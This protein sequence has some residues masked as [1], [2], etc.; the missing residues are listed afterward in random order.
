MFII[1]RK[2]KK[3]KNDYINN[4]I[5]ERLDEISLDGGK[6]EMIILYL[7]DVIEYNIIY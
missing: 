1:G 6:Y 7:F 2:M 4:Y 3:K 5:V